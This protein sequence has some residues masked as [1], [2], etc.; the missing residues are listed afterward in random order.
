MLKVDRSGMQWSFDLIDPGMWINPD[1]VRKNNRIKSDPVQLKTGSDLIQKRI[2][3]DPHS[4]NN[5]NPKNEFGASF[6]GDPSR[7]F[8]GGRRGPSD[9]SQQEKEDLEIRFRLTMERVAREKEAMYM[10]A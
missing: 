3:F 1:P 10:G 2:T 5:K 7:P 8:E 9:R 4:R 6:I